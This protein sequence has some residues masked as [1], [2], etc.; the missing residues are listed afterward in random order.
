MIERG[1]VYRV[2]DATRELNVVPI[3]KN[4]WN[5]RMIGV[6]CVPLLEGQ[7]WAS[8]HA[9]HVEAFV[10]DPARFLVVPKEKFGEALAG[11]PD[12]VLAS[13]ERAV[14]DLLEV[15]RLWE[16]P[17]RATRSP[18]GAFD[19]PRWGE[20]YY[21]AGE[22]FDGEAKRYVVVSG[23]LWN[24]QRRT[25]LVVRLTSQPKYPSDEFPEVDG[26]HACCGE[27]A[28]VSASG[29]DLKRRPPT[30]P[31]R[32]GLGEMSSIAR[33]VCATHLLRQFLSEEEID[34]TR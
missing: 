4:S 19:Y 31:K 28:A 13:L 10:A 11:L 17:P 33:G 15:D 8:P 21:R 20:I 12:E 29:L 26:S 5:Q 25:V 18:A 9:V 30:G 34:A 1:A 24:R 6:G 7:D 23:D 3:T 2:A 22:R 27:L 14:A 16:S 32:L